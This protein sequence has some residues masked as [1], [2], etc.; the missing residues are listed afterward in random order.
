MDFLWPT[1]TRERKAKLPEFAGSSPPPPSSS[2]LRLIHFMYRGIRG[3]PVD[4]NNNFDFLFSR[5]ISFA[6]ESLNPWIFPGKG[7]SK[8]W[9]FEGVEGRRP[10]KIRIYRI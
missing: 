10:G 2:P 4:K 9:K 1:S 5:K 8:W 3:R 6:L 7:K